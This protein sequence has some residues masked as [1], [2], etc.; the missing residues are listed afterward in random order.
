MKLL[1]VI[2]INTIYNSIKQTR[3]TVDFI[4]NIEGQ[5]SLYFLTSLRSFNIYRTLLR[6]FDES[7]VTCREW[8]CSQMIKYNN[9]KTK[10]E[11]QCH[12]HA[13]HASHITDVY[14]FGRSCDVLLPVPAGRWADLWP[15]S[16]GWRS[17]G[18]PGSLS[19]HCEPC[20]THDG[21][22]TTLRHPRLA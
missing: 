1:V 10:K 4:K 7:V 16:W 13:I 22:R 11:E 21:D 3:N 5:S 20:W 8:V 18:A 19:W 14:V 6:M 9:K 12:I 17:R 15:A 2:S